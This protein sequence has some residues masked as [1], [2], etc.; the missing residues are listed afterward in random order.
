MVPVKLASEACTRC[1]R[2]RQSMACIATVDVRTRI[3]FR[4]V[5]APAI[6]TPA[7]DTQYQLLRVEAAVPIPK[8]A[9]AASYAPLLCAGVTVFNSMRHM[10]VTPGELVGIQG[11]GGLGHLAVQYAAKMGYR[12]AALSSTGAK[13][14]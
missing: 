7:Q 5:F 9:D 13:E 4:A 1:A 8:D 2:T 14:K 3:S 12:V 11:L 10:N 6:L